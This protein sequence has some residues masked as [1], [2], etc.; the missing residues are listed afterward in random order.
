MSGSR[1]LVVDDDRHVR[2]A[3]GR[4]LE[5]EQYEVSSAADG[6]EALELVTDWQPDAL[7]LDV[8]MPVLDGLAV[9][10][11]L[12]ERGDRTPVLIA[13]A[14]QALDDR[15]DGL[16][17]GADDYLVKP[18]ELAEL[19]ARLRALLRRAYPAGDEHLSY[20]PLSLDL[21]T[22]EASFDGDAIA[23]TRTEATLLELFLRNPNQVLTRGLIEERIW[24]WDMNSP[25]SLS[26]Y[27]TYLRRKLEEGG[28]PRVIQT[29][30]GVGYRLGRVE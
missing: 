23:L 10:R 26:V 20:G 1:V 13:T 4:A 15:V 9:C 2:E 18:F 12:R 28:R 29:V 25:N 24:G 8:M 21:T 5:V 3:V 19:L 22:H 17:A 14:R 30:R 16:D 27:M 6:A 7:I 11:R